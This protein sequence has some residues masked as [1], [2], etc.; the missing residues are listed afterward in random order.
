MTWQQIVIA[1]WLALVLAAQLVRRIE[2]I[3]GGHARWVELAQRAAAR[4]AAH[5]GT[6]M[7]A[8]I[9]SVVIL[10]CAIM[11]GIAYVLHCGGFW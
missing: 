3:Q 11:I 5:N 10:R 1:I 2:T 9:A 8:R 4:Q 7:G 6:S